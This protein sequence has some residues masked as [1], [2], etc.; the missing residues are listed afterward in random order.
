MDLR[1]SGLL[2]LDVQGMCPNFR[3]AKTI[4]GDLVVTDQF[5]KPFCLAQTL[6]RQFC[7]LQ[8]SGLSFLV[9]VI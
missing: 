3:S 2:F 9:R 6:I 8:S 7:D 4:D 5:V 1:E